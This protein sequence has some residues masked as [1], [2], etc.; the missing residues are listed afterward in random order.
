M[1]YGGS[2]ASDPRA[3]I[4][5]TTPP[6]QLHEAS[7]ALLDR[8]APL[9]HSGQAGA[10]PP[11]YDDPMSLYESDPDL[12]VQ[13]WRQAIRRGRV[14]LD[15]D[16]WR[17]Y[18]VV[19]VEEEPVGMQDLIADQITTHGTVATFSW[20]AADFRGQRLGREMRHAI[21]QLALDGLGAREATSSAFLDNGGSNAI[22]RALGYEPDGIEWQTRCG[23]PARMQRWRLSCE[24]WQ[25][26]RRDDIQLDGVDAYAGG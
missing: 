4:I 25:R 19:V 23:E 1:N 10:D 18:F 2:M 6:L 24:V 3:Q 12:R 13:R 26:V 14:Q 22:S 16:S 15:S 8:L 17:R 20:L 21:L 7:D 5:V 11:P 9:V